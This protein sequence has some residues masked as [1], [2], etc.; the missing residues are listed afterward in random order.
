MPTVDENPFWVWTPEDIGAD[1]A[2]QLFVDIF[3][4]FPDVEAPNHTF[5]HGPRGSGK[6]MMFRMMRPDCASRR[7][8]CGLRELKYLGLY[9]PI[10]R[11]EISQTELV[12]L[13]RHPARYVLNEHLLCIYFA[14]RILD[15]LA[16]GRL[17]YQADSSAVA[18]LQEWADTQF[19]ALLGEKRPIVPKAPGHDVP[20]DTAIRA[21]FA[22]LRNELQPRWATIE[23]LVRSLPLNPDALS[24]YSGPLY[25]Y[26]AFLL[27]LLAGLGELPFLPESAIYLL[28]DDADNLSRT[29]TEILNSWIATRTTAIVCI[30]AS[31]QLRYKTRLT[32]GGQ[33]VEAPHDYHEIDISVLYTTKKEHY[34]DRLELIVEKRL[35][36]GEEKRLEAAEEKRLKTGEEKR[37]K[38]GELSVAPRGFFP[39]DPEQEEGIRKL[40]DEYRR[41]AEAGEGRGHRPRDDAN[42]YARPEFIRLLGGGR[43]STHTYSYS[44]FEQLAHIS[45]G[46]VRWFLEPAAEMYSE[47]NSRGVPV[48]CI[49]PPVQD[50]KIRGF[51][52]MFF[53]SE[54]EKMKEEARDLEAEIGKRE[55]RETDYQRLEYLIN[56]LGQTFFNLLVDERRSERRVFSIALSD[57]ADE[58]VERVLRLGVQEGY[59]YKTSIGT[60]SG[61]GRTARYVLSRRLAPY[62]SLD[63]TSFSGYLFVT[64]ENLR[65]A[66][67]NPK[68][69]LR[70][71]DIA[72]DDVQL[73]LPIG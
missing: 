23:T 18:R 64:N 15:E 19:T 58:E 38:A 17:A 41:R 21:I 9:I 35:K 36:A 72:E 10:K 13:D 12:F 55:E 40:A 63:P 54:F 68:A 24:S 60:K 5:I 66:M 69:L 47:E 3:T 67:S 62:F 70:N 32:I 25:S 50:A 45:S 46:V 14:S 28:V 26:H 61:H 16:S 7:R 34:L 53:S 57:R 20:A 29:Q 48:K 51:S 30:K 73:E 43:K 31:T 33:R 6:S 39:E 22:T 2:V 49:S 59:L 1:L 27:P 42:R 44:G 52:E 56:A 65:R 8:Q 37:L 71:S 4:D 11:T